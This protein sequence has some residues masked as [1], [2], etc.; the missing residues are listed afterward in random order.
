MLIQLF[1][2]TKLSYCGAEFSNPTGN[3]EIFIVL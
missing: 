2:I 1:F 3:E